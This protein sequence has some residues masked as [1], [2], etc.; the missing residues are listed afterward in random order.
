MSVFWLNKSVDKLDKSVETLDISEG[1]F[2]ESVG[3]L[4]KS[5]ESLNISMLDVS[6][7][8]FKKYSPISWQL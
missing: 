6:K 4:D 1:W 8:L 5:V 2:N 3:M 7:F